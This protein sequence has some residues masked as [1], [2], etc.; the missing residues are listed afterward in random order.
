VKHNRQRAQCDQAGK[1][2]VDIDPGIGQ[3][4]QVSQSFGRANPFADDSAYGGID[5]RQSQPG[6]QGW[7]REG[8][9]D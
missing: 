9:A 3:Q 4:H 2:Q 7:Q 8:D 5:R 1:H 6:A